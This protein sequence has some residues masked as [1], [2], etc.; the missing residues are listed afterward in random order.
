MALSQSDLLRLLESLR[1]ADGLEL[2]RGIAE[3][4]LQ[5][6]IEA[7][8]AAHIG[9]GWNEHTEART[10]LR[11]GH[12][13]KTLTTQ[14]GDLELAIPKLRAGSFF[15][16]LLERRR[17]I[18]QAL[19]AVIV[20]AY[21]HG[22]ST[23]SVDDLV[24]ALGAD[25]GISK[26]EVSRI[27][28]D[29]DEPLTA[30]RTRPLDHTR[31]PYMYLDATYCKARVNHQIVSRAV[32]VATGITEDGGREVLGVMVGDSETEAFWAEFLRSLRERGLTGVRLVL[33]DSHSGL[34]KAIRKVMLGA[35]WQRCRVHFLRNVFAVI[36]KEATEMVAATIRTVFAQPTQDAVRTQLDTVAEMLGK[37]FPKVKQML[38]DAKDDLTAFAAFPERHWKKIQSTNPLERINREI[39]RRTDVVQVFP[40]DDALLRLVTAVLFELH[41]EWIAFPRRYLPE[42]SMDEIYPTEL[43]KSAPAPPNATNAPTE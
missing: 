29:L 5:E 4:M 26:S 16:S 9:A 33:S 13:E 15:P 3:R 11:N 27:C 24:K 10:A 38:L 8:A 36:P 43:P 25:T 6:L 35:A 19:Y 42:G 1:S 7:E 30:F 34:V 17:R 21:V 23:R 2:V 22:V 41:D 31:F 20:E 40:N 28:A 12:R 18:D 39:K 32:V 37:Q 14:A